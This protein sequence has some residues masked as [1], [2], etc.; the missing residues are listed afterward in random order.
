M[1]T[2]TKLQNWYHSQCNG[3]WEHGFGVKIETLDNPGWKISINLEDTDLEGKEFPEVSYGVGENAD[4]SGDDWIICKVVGKKFE[5]FGGPHKFE[6]LLQVF[7]KW[8]DA[9][10]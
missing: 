7:L 8:K 6:E 10:K 1:N 3:D 5:A 4:A 2:I 9:V